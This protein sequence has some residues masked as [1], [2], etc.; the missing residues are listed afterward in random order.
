MYRTNRHTV[1][2][3]FS[4]EEAEQLERTLVEAHYLGLALHR[5]GRR[6]NFSHGRATGFVADLLIGW[7]LLVGRTLRE[8]KPIRLP[9]TGLCGRVFWNA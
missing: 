7:A 2:N 1:K 9:P 6:E 5:W 4:P 8:E 3:D